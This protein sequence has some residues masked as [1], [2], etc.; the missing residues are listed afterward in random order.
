MS[1]TPGDGLDV[2][3]LDKARKQRAAERE[4]KQ[5]SL[6]I[7]VGG[8]VVAEL[9]VELP[10]DVLA[11]L[12][13]LDESITLVLR[14]SMKM[15]GADADARARWDGT[16]LIVDLLAAN[17]TLPVDVLNVLRKVAVNLLSESG[18]D[19]LMASRPSPEDLSYLAKGVFRFYGV[20][21]GEVSPSSDSSTDSGRTSS[22][23]SS[24]TSESTPEVSGTPQESPASLASVGS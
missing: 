22:T 21:L 20:T 15:Y 14:T 2:I 3:D 4:G 9:P 8:Q 13:D 1:E 10:V 11:P 6:P 7:R 12:K 19:A 17:P 23:T 18:Y 24:V 16:E 5:Q